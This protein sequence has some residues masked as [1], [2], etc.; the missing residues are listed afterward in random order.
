MSIVEHV[1]VSL[2]QEHKIIPRDINFNITDASEKVWFDKDQFKTSFFNALFTLFP[3]G[4]D[5][6]VRSVIHYRDQISSKKLQEDITNFAIQEGFHSRCHADHLDVLERQGYKSLKFENK[7]IDAGMR[8]MNRW[9]PKFS[10][11]LTVALEH[12]TAMLSHQALVYPELFSNPADDDFRPLMLWHGL[13]ELEH[14]AVAFDVYKEVDGRHWPLVIAMIVATISLAG[15]TVIRMIP[16]LFKDK[17]LFSWKAWREGLPFL[18]GRHGMFTI[19][20]RIYF[21]F[22]DPSFHPWDIDDSDLASKTRL[23]YEN[24]TLLSAKAS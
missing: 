22:Y 23:M 18:Y 12:F 24:G 3:P 17:I 9:I 19:S 4:E 21:R 6:F 8:A 7:F 13:E 10:L 1:P 15:F 14:K 2:N 20:W 11:A 16:L 5:F